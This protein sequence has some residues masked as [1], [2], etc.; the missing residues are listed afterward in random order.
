MVIL[1]TLVLFSIIVFAAALLSH[2]A[3]MIAEKYGPNFAGSIMDE[4]DVALGSA[5]GAAIVHLA[6]AAREFGR[7]HRIKITRERFIK[8][9][10][11]LIIGAAVK[12]R[13][14]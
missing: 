2:G 7:K 10:G 11:Y 12:V 13:S 9:A 5:V 6:M 8:G 1:E 14:Q 3:E 4:Y